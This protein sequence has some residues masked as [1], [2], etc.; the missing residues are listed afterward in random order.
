MQLK[1][2]S[3]LGRVLSSQCKDNEDVL[4]GLWASAAP[5]RK[6]LQTT[7]YFLKVVFFI[8]LKVSIFGIAIKIVLY[9]SWTKLLFHLKPVGTRWNSDFTLCKSL[10]KSSTVPLVLELW[11]FQK[12]AVCRTPASC[13]LMCSCWLDALKQVH[14]CRTSPSSNEAHW[15]AGCPFVCQQLSCAD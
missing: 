10:R 4:N 15:A 12:E 6:Q 11:T 3:G 14:T 8:F 7:T 1:M 9:F 13:L 2:Q 5:V